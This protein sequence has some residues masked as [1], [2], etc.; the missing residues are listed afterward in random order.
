MTR[1][2]EISERSMVLA[3]R[4]MNARIIEQAK[5]VS[6]RGPEPEEQWHPVKIATVAVFMVAVI[7][8]LSIIGAVLA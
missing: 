2:E 5:Q 3:R 8:A 1:R 4:R 6:V 7:Y